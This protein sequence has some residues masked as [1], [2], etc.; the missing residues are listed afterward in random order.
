MYF[1]HARQISIIVLWPITDESLG[2]ARNV[3]VYEDLRV[4]HVP[5]VYT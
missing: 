5:K 3:F 4:Q 2:D 1:A